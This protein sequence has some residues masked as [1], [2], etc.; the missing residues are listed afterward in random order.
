MDAHQLLL[1]L[2]FMQAL[3]IEG[4]LVLFPFSHVTLKCARN[5]GLLYRDAV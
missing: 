5:C 3:L 2:Q 4:K 1:Y